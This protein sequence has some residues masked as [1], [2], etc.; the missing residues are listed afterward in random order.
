MSWSGQSSTS[1][2]EKDLFCVSW[3]CTASFHFSRK[4]VACL[5][6]LPG[7]TRTFCGQIYEGQLERQRRRE[8][9]QAIERAHERIAKL[10]NWGNELKRAVVKEFQTL[11]ARLPQKTI[12][13]EPD[14][15]AARLDAIEARVGAFQNVVTACLLRQAGGRHLRGHFQG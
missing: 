5:S 15:I 9:D 12:F 10:E 14:P 1:I 3:A 2:R 7:V 6:P 13:E 4:A 11:G 8:R